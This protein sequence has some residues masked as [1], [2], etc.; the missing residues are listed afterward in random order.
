MNVT[1]MMTYKGTYELRKSQKRANVLT[2]FLL[3]VRRA[4]G[5][6]GIGGAHLRLL[7]ARISIFRRVIGGLEVLAREPLF[8]TGV[9]LEKPE[10]FSL[11]G[12]H[13][14]NHLPERA[15]VLDA[16]ILGVGILDG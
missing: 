14:R 2:F 3:S 9:V 10:E 5:P 6:N 12:D 16:C 1:E 4:T 7:R 8:E 13:I 11:I 15:V